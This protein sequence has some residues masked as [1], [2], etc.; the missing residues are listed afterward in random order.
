MG[1]HFY[2]DEASGRGEAVRRALDAVISAECLWV[3][4]SLVSLATQLRRKTRNDP[5]VVVVSSDQEME[6]LVALAEDLWDRRILLVVH[7]DAPGT[8]R[9]GHTVRPRI[10]LCP[11]EDPRLVAAVAARMLEGRRPW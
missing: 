2:A 1:L 8:I 9:R 5:A 11:Q 6:A 4:R 10:L 7:D 3:H